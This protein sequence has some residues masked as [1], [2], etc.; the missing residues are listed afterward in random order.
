MFLEVDNSG[1]LEEQP[2]HIADPIAL[3]VRED[4]QESL[5]EVH[6][7][8]ISEDATAP[9]V[10]VRLGW[11]DY[12]K[13]I[14]HIEIAIR[15]PGNDPVTVTTIDQYF[16]QDTDVAKAAAANLEDALAELAKPAPR[17]D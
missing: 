6:G 12:P 7:I 4:V 8:K 17:D 3:W 1:L 9:A 13:S 11:V 15:R 10:I 2:A 14:Y 5:R 16:L